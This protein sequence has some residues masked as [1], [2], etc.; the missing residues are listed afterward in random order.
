MEYSKEQYK[1]GLLRFQRYHSDNTM[2]QQT[3]NQAIIDVEKCKD[4]IGPIPKAKISSKPP[5]TYQVGL[6]KNYTFIV[7]SHGKYL[8]AYGLYKPCIE[9]LAKLNGNDPT[10]FFNMKKFLPVPMIVVIFLC[11]SCRK[12]Q[13]SF[14]VSDEFKQWTLFKSG[15]IWIYKNE[16]TNQSDTAYVNADAISNSGGDL[17]LRPDEVFNEHIQLSIQSHF[18][19]TFDLNASSPGKDY[20]IIPNKYGYG[21]YALRLNL[22]IGHPSNTASEGFYLVESFPKLILNNNEFNNVLHTR[23]YKYYETHDTLIFDYY[24]AKNIGLIKHSRRFKSTDTTWSL[25]KWHTNQ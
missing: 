7:F 12:Q 2:V 3:D 1:Q 19:Y 24:F 13:Q 25:M 8:G 20:L 21:S 6:S 18:L 11:W 14:Y 22:G 10:T 23:S 9:T 4:I 5:L 17:N 16:M 15:T